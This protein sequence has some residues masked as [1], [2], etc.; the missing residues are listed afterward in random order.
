MRKYKPTNGSHSL[1]YANQLLMDN[2][3][4]RKNPLDSK[5]NT[6]LIRL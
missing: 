3:R 5:L 6:Q 2:N 4:K 1:F